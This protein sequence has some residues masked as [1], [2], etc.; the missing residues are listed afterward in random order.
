M[1]NLFYLFKGLF[2]I[3]TIPIGAIVCFIA[4]IIDFGRNPYEEYSE[5]WT[6]REIEIRER[7]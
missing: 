2:M 5:D 3:I 6:N 1:K 7:R 4:L